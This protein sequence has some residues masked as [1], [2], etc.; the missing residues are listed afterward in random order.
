MKAQQV[1]K[2][3]IDYKTWYIICVF[4]FGVLM[5]VWLL[6]LILKLLKYI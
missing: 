5:G 6:G 1:S 4:L 3:K 2:G